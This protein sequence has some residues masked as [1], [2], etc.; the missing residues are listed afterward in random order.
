MWDKRKSR[1]KFPTITEK[2]AVNRVKLLELSAIRLFYDLQHFSMSR[3]CLCRHFF[4]SSNFLLLSVSCSTS[5]LQSSSR[6]LPLVGS[7]CV[8]WLAF[9]CFP[10]SQRVHTLVWE[11]NSHV[12]SFRPSIVVA[13]A[14]PFSARS[15]PGTHQLLLCVCYPFI[16]TKS[17]A[18]VAKTTTARKEGQ[19]LGSRQ[20]HNTKTTHET[21]L[22]LCQ[23]TQR[24]RLKMAWAK[25]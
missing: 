7:A 15:L 18:N 10:C 3:T 20:K 1:P 4:C 22:T 17:T 24:F 9:L 2:T 6:P 8:S 12:H 21:H 11:Q 14:S 23:R 19:S 25:K 13:S 5:L 16:I